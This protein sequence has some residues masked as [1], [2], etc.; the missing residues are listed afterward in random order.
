M[1]CWYNI[2]WK[3]VLVLFLTYYHDLLEKP[4]LIVIGKTGTS[5]TAHIMPQ[6]ACCGQEVSY[7]LVR[8]VMDRD[9]ETE[10]GTEIQRERETE[11][12]SDRDTPFCQ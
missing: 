9:L 6:V 8:Q 11:S 12:T 2:T 5:V 10:R 4:H 1:Y 3:D 7:Q